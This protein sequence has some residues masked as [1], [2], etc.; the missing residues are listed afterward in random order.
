MQI[1]NVIVAKRYV[2]LFSEKFLMNN[3]FDCLEY[4]QNKS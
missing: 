3:I 2:H 1:F 4:Y